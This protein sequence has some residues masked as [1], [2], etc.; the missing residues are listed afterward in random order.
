MNVIEPVER[1]GIELLGVLKRKIMKDFENHLLVLEG[2][3]CSF[4]CM[5]AMNGQYTI[6]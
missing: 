3:K 5:K 2:I 1:N 6:I 4:H